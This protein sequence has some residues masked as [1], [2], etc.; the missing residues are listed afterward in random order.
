M[1]KKTFLI[2]E[3]SL[4]GILIIITLLSIFPFYYVF[5]M[6][7]Y[8]S[9]NIL[10]KGITLI[11]GT[12]LLNNL[13]NV[14]QR[15]YVQS[16][17]NSIIVSVFATVGSVLICA[18]AGYGLSLYRFRGRRFLKNLIVLTMLLPPQIGIIG[19]IIE[20]RTLGISR[21]FLSLILTWF[22]NSFGC[23]WII[24]YLNAH[25]QREIVESARIDGA[26]EFYIF[27][28]I[29]LPLM[30]T[31]IMTLVMLTFLWSWNSYMLPLIIV[32]KASMYTIPLYVMSINGIFRTDY[33]AQMTALFFATI[34]LLIIF[35]LGS[36]YFQKG[37]VAGAIKG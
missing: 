27:S 19:Y 13:K 34:P 17:V 5:I 15:N 4:K 37:L 23:F 26:N 16:Y 30:R 21:T 32:N 36:K 11:P 20:M 29:S 10:R 12:Y 1:R 6:A 8:F 3:Y 2:R 35:I 33:S 28:I 7:S 14:L 25:L 22:P 18:A 31:A 24:Q 9:E